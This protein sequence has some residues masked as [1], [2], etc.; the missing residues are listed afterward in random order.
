LLELFEEL[1]PQ[2][3]VMAAVITR[4]AAE[5]ATLKDRDERGVRMIPREIAI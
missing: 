5:A 4:V 3:M 2:A 1:L